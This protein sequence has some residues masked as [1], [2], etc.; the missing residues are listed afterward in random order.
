MILEALEAEVGTELFHLAE[1]CDVITV[2]ATSIRLLR[3]MSSMIRYPR[4]IQPNLSCMTKNPSHIFTADPLM[5]SFHTA[6][7]LYFVSQKY[8][9]SKDFFMGFLSRNFSR[10]FSRDFFMGIFSW[11]S[12]RIFS[13]DFCK[14]FLSRDF[15][16][17][18]LRNCFKGNFS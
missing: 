17:G 10:N 14:G 13:W 6:P 15:L 18:F 12:L 8:F 7:N 5:V 3:T 16:R 4:Q 2:A 1:L 9:F 11:D